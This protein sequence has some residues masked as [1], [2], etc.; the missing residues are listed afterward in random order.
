M[1]ADFENVATAT[2]KPPTGP[3]VKAADHAERRRSQAFV[4][5]QHPRIAIVKSPKHQTLTTKL[6][7]TKNANGATKTTVTLRHRAL[8]DQ[9]HEHRRTSRCTAS[10]SATRSRRTA[11]GRI[12]TPPG[13]SVEDL[14]LHARDGLEQLHERRDRDRHLAQGRARSRRTDHATSTVEGQDDER[15]RRQRN[16]AGQ[17]SPAA[18]RQP[19]TARRS[20]PARPERQAEQRERAAK[21]LPALVSG[22][23]LSRHRLASRRACSVGDPRP[24]SPL[25]ALRRRDRRGRARARRVAR[26]ASTPPPEGDFDAVLVL[27]GHMNVGEEPDHP[28]LED[29][30]E[31][32]R[33]LVDVR[34]PA[35]RDLPRR[36]DA[37]PRARRAR[38]RPA[39][40][41][42]RVRRG[43]ADEG[44]GERPGARRAARAL[45]GARRQPLRLQGAAARRSSS[46]PRTSSRRPSGWATGPGRCSSTPRRAAGRCSRWFEEDEEAGRCRG[47]SPS[48][49]ASSRRRSTA[50]TGSA[51]SSACAFLEAARRSRL[52]A[53]RRSRPGCSRRTRRARARPR[54]A[55]AARPGR[56]TR[57]PAAIA[58]VPEPDVTC[59][60][61]RSRPRPRP[62]P[63]SGSSLETHR[64]VSD[65]FAVF[66]YGVS[67]LVRNAFANAV[68][69]SAVAARACSFEAGG[70]V[71]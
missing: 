14:H 65:R 7:T 15:G 28:W 38:L 41:A 27:G 36:P 23:H 1:N 13:R 22:V 17:D 48:S 10:R 35:L 54:A 33:D 16:R 62:R 60:P 37:R 50:G 61:R 42:G 21:R 68:H 56:A 39:R 4:P 24:A 44:G 64:R 47:R 49:S 25:R 29:E 11:T 19:G 31:M 8:H 12:G 46:R 26:S 66:E 43:S 51:G 53:N 30:Y 34:A 52:A 59:D 2:G 5:P 58:A 67:L 3:T 69:S 57:R 20:S 18:P 32:L 9:G 45:R 55:A 40:A 70:Q 63:A 6:T 71:T